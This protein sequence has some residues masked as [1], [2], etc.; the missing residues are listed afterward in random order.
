M[1]G[2]KKTALGKH[3]EPPHSQD[4]ASKVNNGMKPEPLS[5]LLWRYEE[6][7]LAHKKIQYQLA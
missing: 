6:K 2:F 3:N 7:K 1:K 5:L 4:Y